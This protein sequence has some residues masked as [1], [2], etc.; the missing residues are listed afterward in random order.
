MTIIK[1][2]IGR[3]VHIVVSNHAKKPLQFHRFHQLDGSVLQITQVHHLS[4]LLL[5]EPLNPA[6]SFYIGI[7]KHGY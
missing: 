3:F 5:I 4:Y 2:V 1:G 7:T 6:H